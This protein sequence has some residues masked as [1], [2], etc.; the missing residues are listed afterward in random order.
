MKP[1]ASLFEGILDADY[2][3]NDGA[4]LDDVIKKAMDTKY[5]HELPGVTAEG[6]W[7]VFDCA[8]IHNDIFFVTFEPIRKAGYTKYRF[9]NCTSIDLYKRY[10]GT[11]H[12]NGVEI[13]APDSELL[14]SNNDSLTLGRF[15]AN[16]KNVYIDANDSDNMK[17]VMKNCKFDA[18]YI[19]TQ[20]VTQLSIADTCKFIHTKLLYL[21]RAGKSVARKALNLALSDVRNGNSFNREAPDFMPRDDTMYWDIDVMKVLSLQANKWPDLGKIV[22]VPN[23]IPAT[24][25]PGICLYRPNK[26]M[27][28]I[29]KRYNP[30]IAEYKNGWHG[31]HIARAKTELNCVTK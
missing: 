1:L 12:W 23:G 17:I 5:D 15:T 24:S 29:S 21:G 10:A 13:D 19:R 11:D 9:V 7:L 3:I 28:P 26:A 16:V 4:I 25:A 8:K 20:A 2:D 27:Y 31:S 18:A 6:E 22:I 30:F 14:F